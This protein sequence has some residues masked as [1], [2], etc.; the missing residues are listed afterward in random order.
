MKRIASS[1]VRPPGACYSID[2]LRPAPS[3]VI[4]VRIV[5][6]LL[7][8]ALSEAVALPALAATADQTAL[9][10]KCAHLVKV[11]LG[12]KETGSVE[13]LRGV[14]AAVEMVDRCVANNGKLD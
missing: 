2:F 13:D 1:L 6:L 5:A 4:M 11:R 10:R 3:E 8:V 14:R 12:I 9:R 7:V